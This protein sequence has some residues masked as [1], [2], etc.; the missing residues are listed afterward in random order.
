MSTLGDRPNHGFRGIR[1]S[2]N[3][4]EGPQALARDGNQDD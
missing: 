3:G 1:E 4:L 2:N